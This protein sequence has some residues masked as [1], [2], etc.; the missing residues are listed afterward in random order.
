MSYPM[1]YQRVIHR[2]GL[3]E[4]GY[5]DDPARRYS[6]VGPEYAFPERSK[7]AAEVDYEAILRGEIG[8]L[9]GEIDRLHGQRMS[10]LGDL[11]RLEA[12]ALDERAICQHIASRTG[13]DV[14][15]VA[16]VLQG[17]MTC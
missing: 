7:F 13:I 14:E 8:N 5:T 16:A 3:H 1:T 6:K 10:L 12:D 4:G 15:T 2:N 11:R 17:F 9:R